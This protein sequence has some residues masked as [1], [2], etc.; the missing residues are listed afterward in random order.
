MV[1]INIKHTNKLFI[2]TYRYEKYL[3]SIIFDS[4]TFQH[5]TTTVF[6]YKHHFS[7]KI[8]VYDY[9]YFPQVHYVLTK[10]ISFT[11]NCI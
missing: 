6:Q 4:I 8:F 5:I 3:N 10:R 2:H 11:Y 7:H 1:K 9:D